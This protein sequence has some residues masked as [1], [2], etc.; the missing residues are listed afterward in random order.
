MSKYY[1]YYNPEDDAYYMKKT[2]QEQKV[3]LKVKRKEKK[4][5]AEDLDGVH[6]KA[7]AIRR[8]TLLEKIK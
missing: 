1:S 4:Q 5:N 2:M 3:I 8:S 6:W 7:L